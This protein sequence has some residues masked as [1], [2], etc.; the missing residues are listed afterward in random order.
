MKYLKIDENSLKMRNY[1]GYL[2]V[3]VM[4]ID[5]LRKVVAWQ[6]LLIKY[7]DDIGEV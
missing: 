7:Y 6:K 4:N 1:D 2:R 3:D 5:A